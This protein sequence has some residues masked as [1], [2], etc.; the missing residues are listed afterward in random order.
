M[1]IR[2]RT[3]VTLVPSGSVPTRLYGA[4]GYRIGC[5]CVAARHHP[6]LRASRTG[7]R[8]DHQDVAGAPDGGGSGTEPDTV[9][10]PGQCRPA[11]A[12]ELDPG[13]V[14]GRFPGRRRLAGVEV[15]E[16]ASGDGPDLL[17][18]ASV[19]GLG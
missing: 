8:E 5:G 4:S 18:E 1:M 10:L 15:R 2:L 12:A 16:G 14:L 9:E 19:V 11:V 7:A 3:S 13:V 6:S 17:V